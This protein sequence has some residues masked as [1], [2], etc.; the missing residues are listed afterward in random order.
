MKLKVSLLLASLLILPAISN[1]MPGKCKGLNPEQITS[2][3]DLADYLQT[4]S[5]GKV[6]T[7]FQRESAGWG[8]ATCSSIDKTTFSVAKTDYVDVLRHEVDG[9]KLA[10][11]CVVEAGDQLFS[12]DAPRD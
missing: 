8:V 12:C 5:L 6:K 7:T 10:Y 4:S 3:S 11:C 9:S 2:C 1:A